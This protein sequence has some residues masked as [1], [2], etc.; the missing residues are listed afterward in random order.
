[1]TQELSPDPD[2]VPHMSVREFRRLGY[3]QEVNRRFFHPLGLA[4]EVMVGDYEE[5]FGGVKDLRDDPE[6]FV[7]G[8]VNPE[9]VEFVDAELEK[10]QEA[11]ET[12]MGDVVQP[13]DWELSQT[14][15]Q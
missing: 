4:L 2:P 6:G 3:L 9:Y 11:R 12:L 15:S 1:V 5:H 10:R 13:V 8:K 14:P 7:F